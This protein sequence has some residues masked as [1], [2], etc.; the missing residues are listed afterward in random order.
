MKKEQIVA[1]VKYGAE[2]W[3]ILKKMLQTACNRSQIQGDGVLILRQQFDAAHEF[4]IRKMSE[5]ANKAMFAG[6]V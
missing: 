3:V 6:V 1:V 5:P 4:F 2:L